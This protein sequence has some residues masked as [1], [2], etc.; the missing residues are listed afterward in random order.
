M[1]NFLVITIGLL[2]TGHLMAQGAIGDV[3]GE[4]KNFETGEPLWGAEVFIESIGSKY[5]ARTDVDGR[6]RVTG[7]TAGTHIVHVQY[8]GDT[9]AETL[10]AVVPMDG[11]ENLGLIRFS[12]SIVELGPVDVSPGLKLEYGSLPVKELTAEDIKNSPSKFNIKGLV[13]AMSSEVK[14]TEDGELVFRGARK[15]DMLYLIDGVK[16]AAIGSMPSAAIARMQVYS[17]GLPAKY[18]DTTGGVVVMESKGYFDLWNQ[19]YAR[20]LKNGNL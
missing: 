1:K 9:M 15:G 10:T 2:L 8:K 7:I 17:G 16:T 11:I 14:M 5:Q 18:G 20:E 12:T 13:T 19:W 4:V 3:V 6:F